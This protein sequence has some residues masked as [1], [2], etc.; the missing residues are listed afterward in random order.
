MDALTM[1]LNKSIEESENWLKTAS[2]ELLGV[3]LR[4]EEVAQVET[5]I[6]TLKMVKQLNLDIIK[7][8]ECAVDAN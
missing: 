7:S 6:R 1:E 3:C 4:S 8:Q 2:G 5:V